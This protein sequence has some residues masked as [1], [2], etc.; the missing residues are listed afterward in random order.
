MGKLG[1]LIWDPFIRVPPKLANCR[2]GKAKHSMKFGTH[3]G[4]EVGP[5]HVEPYSEVCTLKDCN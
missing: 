4:L 3:S 5:P 2:H 1:S